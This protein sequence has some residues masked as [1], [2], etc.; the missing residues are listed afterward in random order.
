M[1][2]RKRSRMTSG[3]EAVE[4]VE[5]V[6]RRHEVEQLPVTPE[7]SLNAGSASSD[8][9]YMNSASIR[10]ELSSFNIKNGQY[11]YIADIPPAVKDLSAHRTTVFS[12]SATSTAS[13]ASP[14]QT[15][16]SHSLRQYRRKIS[17]HVT[18]A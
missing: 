3:L 4:E 2:P 10:P 13:V 6:I 9:H 5:V 14:F 17:I 15:L 1:A 16:P 11:L 12:H 8:A 18:R 7:D